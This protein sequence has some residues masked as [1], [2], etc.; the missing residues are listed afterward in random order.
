MLDL[1]D[2]N[3]VKLPIDCIIYGNLIG[4]SEKHYFNIGRCKDNLSNEMIACTYG[5]VHNVEQKDLVNFEFIGLVKDYS[6]LLE[7]D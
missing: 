2:K 6:H 4:H 3:G 1:K 5:Y 7:C